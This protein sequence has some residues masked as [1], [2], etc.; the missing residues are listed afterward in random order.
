MKIFNKDPLLQ[1]IFKYHLNKH[2]PRE[3]FLQEIFCRICVSAEIYFYK[4]FCRSF[5]NIIWRNYSNKI[6]FCSK[7]LIFIN[8]TWR[9]LF[10]VFFMK[11]MI[12]ADF[13]LS[14]FAFRRLKY[15]QIL[16]QQEY[17]TFS[18][19]AWY[20]AKK[21]FASLNLLLVSRIQGTGK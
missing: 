12:S 9:K 1:K 21:L 20:L 6:S 15:W 11:K 16:L 2:S 13:L 8:I 19:K 5:E 4:D 14:P 3:F 10:R 7:Y 17:I 18:T